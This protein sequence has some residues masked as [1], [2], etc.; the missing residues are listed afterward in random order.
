MTE[1]DRARGAAMAGFLVPAALL[2]LTV[3]A[4]LSNFGWQDGSYVVVFFYI[5]LGSALTGAVVRVAAPAPWR[6]AWSGL[7]T[8]GVAGLGVFLALMVAIYWSLSNSL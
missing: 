1:I 6:S 7:V 5:A 2:V 8:A 4:L 3:V